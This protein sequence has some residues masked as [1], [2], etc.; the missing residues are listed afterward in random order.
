LNA[1]SFEHQP[2]N[3]MMRKDVKKKGKQLLFH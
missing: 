1:G 3:G 2:A